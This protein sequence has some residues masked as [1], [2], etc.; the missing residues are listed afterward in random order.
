MRR[1]WQNCP[2]GMVYPASKTGLMVNG[3]PAT[4]GSGNS[5][6]AGT[7]SIIRMLSGAKG[8]GAA[9][10]VMFPNLSIAR[11]YRLCTPG[12]HDPPI[13]PSRRS[14]TGLT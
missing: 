13:V 2:A 14:T 12:V 1:H 7:S 5:K 11:V 10:C 9:D 4:A 3:C 6:F 8:V